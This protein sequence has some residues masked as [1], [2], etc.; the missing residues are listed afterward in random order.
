MLAVIND[1]GILVVLV[2]AVLL[3]GANRIPKLARNLG[4][5]SREF[6]SAQDEAH[7]GPVADA[8]ALAPRPEPVTMT[9]DQLDALLATAGGHAGPVERPQAAS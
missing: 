3:F 5:A 6:K 8:P 2:A 4:E 9:R 7:P 1:T